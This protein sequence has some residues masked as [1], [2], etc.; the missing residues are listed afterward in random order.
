MAPHGRRRERRYHRW[1]AGL[2]GNSANR[3]L[4]VQK[5]FDGTLGFEGEGPDGAAI[6]SIWNHICKNP[7]GNKAFHIKT[8]L[9]RGWAVSEGQSSSDHNVGLYE[10]LQ[11]IDCLSESLA[12]A[13]AAEISGPKFLRQIRACLKGDQIE[14]TCGFEVKLCVCHQDF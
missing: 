12:Q 6:A 2:R 8:L 11:V 5:R 7:G 9:F 13:M 10:C 14:H 3:C 1:C 4:F